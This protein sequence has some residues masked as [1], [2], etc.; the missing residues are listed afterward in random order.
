MKTYMLIEETTNQ[1]PTKKLEIIVHG[2][3]SYRIYIDLKIFKI[4]A[5]RKT[6]DFEIIKTVP[7]DFKSQTFDLGNASV[8]LEHKDNTLTIKGYVLGRKIGE[9]AYDWAQL[10]EGAI[11]DMPKL[12][13]RGSW[14]DAAIS[15]Q[16]I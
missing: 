4:V 7:L 16:V 11:F 9:Y 6:E 12:E 13:W 8:S 10:Q 2:S 14:I 3:Y 15:F 1:T 5:G